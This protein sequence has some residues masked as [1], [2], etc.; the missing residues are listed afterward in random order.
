MPPGEGHT[1]PRRPA[2][3][4]LNFGVDNLEYAAFSLNCCGCYCG[5]FVG[6]AVGSLPV[7]KAGGIYAH[8][9]LCA[10]HCAASS[11]SAY[12]CVGNLCRVA[13]L[14]HSF[15]QRHGLYG[16]LHGAQRHLSGV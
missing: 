10:Q 14:G 13:F 5:C 7:F 4:H 1:V 15:K 12:A 16:H 6:K 3:R 9:E 11:Q 2:L 8:V